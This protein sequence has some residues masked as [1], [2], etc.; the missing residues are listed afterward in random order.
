MA[1]APAR[2]P[3]HAVA[4][5]L[6]LQEGLAMTASNTLDRPLPILLEWLR[7]HDVEYE[8]HEH[9]PAFTARATASAEGV[10]PRTFAKVVGI[11]TDDGTSILVILDSTDHVDLAKA[12]AALEAADVRLLTEAELAALAPDCEVGAIPAVGSLFGIR[13]VAD[14]AV[15][16]DAEISFNAGTHRFSARV[17][18]PTWER[19]DN[20]VYADIALEREMRPAWS[21]S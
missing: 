14:F 12:R 1:D 16:D 8:I 7:S 13:T 20:V 3:D 21:R 2:R 4:T 9:D 6:R 19:A 5:P 18:R 10:D 11:A 15:R 17:E